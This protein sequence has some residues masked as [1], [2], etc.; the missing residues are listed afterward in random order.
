[1]NRV[2]RF[3][4]LKRN[5][6]Q[7]KFVGMWPRIRPNVFW[8][9]LTGYRPLGM[10]KE[11]GNMVAFCQVCHRP[12]GGMTGAAEADERIWSLARTLGVN[13]ENDG[14]ICADC[15]QRFMKG[16]GALAEAE[17]TA[18]PPGHEAM[19][20]AAWGQIFV[21]EGA[22]PV[23]VLDLGHVSGYSRLFLPD[24]DEE[25]VRNEFYAT[26]LLKNLT[27]AR[28]GDAIYHFRIRLTGVG[29]SVIVAASG[30][31][32]RTGKKTPELK[33]AWDLM[34]GSEELSRR[35]ETK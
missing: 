24:F 25:I 11:G 5:I 6:M 13:L 9:A 21:S 18:Q 16:A 35:E 23:G 26:T 31:A 3:L 30:C 34:H 27:L 33:A 14:R 8:S 29:N 32:A 2:L 1:M 20:T 15:L 12:I 19:L 22:L 4:H 28:R 10:R 7:E 17:L